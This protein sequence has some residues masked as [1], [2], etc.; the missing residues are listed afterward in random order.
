MQPWIYFTFRR[1]PWI[2]YRTIF[3]H[4][5]IHENFINELE[6]WK[7]GDPESDRFK[8]LFE[9]CITYMEET[10]AGSHGKTAQFW[11]NYS[12]LMDMNL[13]MLHRDMKMNDTQL[14]AYV[15]YQIS[16]IFFSTNHQNYARLMTL[17]V[18]IDEFA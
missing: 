9:K 10:M 3:E 8:R 4:N 17:F 15:F 6:S 12:Y 11:I 13:L 1:N 2:T 16:S 14:F 18:G 7:N 5:D